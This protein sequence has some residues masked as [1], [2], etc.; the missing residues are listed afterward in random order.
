[1][2]EQTA[3]VITVSPEGTWVRAV[4]S[5]GCGTCGGQGCSTR[6][7][8]EIFQDRPRGFVVQSSLPLEPGDRVVVG[9][10]PGSVL[11]GAVRA[12]GLPLVAMLA[13]ALMANTLFP[14]DG[15]AAAGLVAGGMFGWL[16]VRG[17]RVHRPVVLR[18]VD[19]ISIQMKSCK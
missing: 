11:S 17:S 3:E 14:G 7:I 6:R 16:A 18:R 12:Y 15:P 10:A 4:E 5:S 13:G 9:I 2:L 8:A 19:A 1:M